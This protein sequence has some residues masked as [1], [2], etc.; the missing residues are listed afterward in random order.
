MRAFVFAL[1]ALAGLM[2]AAG[3]GLA[4]M[5]AHGGGD[6]TLPTAAQFLLF[7]AAALPGAAGLALRCESAGAV[8]PARLFAVAGAM[9]AGGAALFCGDLALRALAGTK[10]FPL[11]APA[12]GTML[13]AGWL[14]LAA[15]AAWAA[16]QMRKG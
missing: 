13:M 3:T 14:V 7:H 15:A 12:G 4:A 9:L 11:A 1:A 16:L 10:L 2:G 8:W 5:A 6:A